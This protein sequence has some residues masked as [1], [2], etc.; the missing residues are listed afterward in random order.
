VL[1]FGHDAVLCL[2]RDPLHCLP[3]TIH[4][5]LC[6]LWQCCLKYLILAIIIPRLSLTENLHLPSLTFPHRGP[7]SPCSTCACEKPFCHTH[8]GCWHEKNLRQA[9]LRTS[10][11][12]SVV[13]PGALPLV[14]LRW[15]TFAGLSNSSPITS[16]PIRCQTSTYAVEGDLVKAPLTSAESQEQHRDRFVS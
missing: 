14:P 4:L 16:R 12:S 6:G 9:V 13:L 7:R 11:R 1:V 3:S 5:C 15:T 8:R 10:A 2:G